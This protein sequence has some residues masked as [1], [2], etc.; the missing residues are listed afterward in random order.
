MLH[1]FDDRQSSEL[2]GSESLRRFAELAP[3]IMNHNILLRERYD[4]FNITEDVRKKASVEHRQLLNAFQRFTE[5]PKDQ[6][7]R[8]ALLKKTATLLYVVRSNIAHSEKTP[9]GPDLSKSERDQVVSEAAS[10]VIEDLFD[11]FFDRPSQRLAVYGTLTPDGPNAS[12]LAGLEGQW[13]E[14]TVHGEVGER[15]G[16]LEFNWSITAEVVS[17]KVLSASRLSERFDRLDRFEGPRY[18]RILVPALIDGKHSVCNIYQGKR[19]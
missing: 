8:E 14:G 18:R 15:D 6:S 1:G 10:G 13:H 3:H 2:C 19:T 11:I 4:P 12:E 17:V 16:F 9:Q 5:L 7:L